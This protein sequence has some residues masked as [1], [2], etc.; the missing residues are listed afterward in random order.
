MRP[1]RILVVAAALL[2]LAAVA[3]VGRPE[4]AHGA[5]SAESKG[6]TVSGSGRV[7][8]TPDWASFSFGVETSA[9]TAA[10]ALSTNSAVTRRVIA[11]LLA[12]GVDRKDLQTELVSL[13]PRTS[14]DGLSIEGYIAQ[15]SVSAT[16]RDLGKAGDVIDAAVGAGA[17]QVSGPS[18]VASDRDGL[19]RDALKAAYA[20]ARAKAQAL[21]GASGAT[22]GRAVDVIESGG[23]V[24]VVL[25]KAAAMGA[26]TPVE[27]GTQEIA[28]T[29]TV[30]FAVS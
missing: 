5:D 27:P 12:A 10:Q 24:P 23:A 1:I 17:N 3:G 29:V 11:A 22:L 26:S 6:I 18:L 2:A 8:T 4:G 14:D 25:D 21:A 30:T 20:D 28:A 13:S 7:T 9:A 15:N 16:I 19:Y